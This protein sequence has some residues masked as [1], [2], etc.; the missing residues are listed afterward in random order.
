MLGARYTAAIRARRRNQQG[1]TAILFTMLSSLLLIPV[2]GLAIDGAVLYLM[3]AK[4]SAAVDATA[5]ATA[6]S[7]SVST[8]YAPAIATGKSYF[9]ANLPDGTFGAHVV[10]GEPLI[11][12][13]DTPPSTYTLTANVQASIQVPL[14]FMRVLGFQT[15]TL[16]DSGAASRRVS[17]IFLVLDR[18]GSLSRSGSCGPLRSSSQDFV[19]QFVDGRDTLALITFQSTA[20][21][22]YPTDGTPASTTFK[23]GSPTLTSVLSRL[24]CD[25]G[26]TTVAALKLAYEAIKQLNQ[27]LANNVIVL[28]TDGRANGF[29][30]EF[31]IKDKPDNR[32]DW[33]LGNPGNLVDM[34]AT[35]CTSPSLTGVVFS[36][37]GYYDPNGVLGYTAGVFE[38]KKEPLDWVSPSGLPEKLVDAS[39]NCSV[40]D[41]PQGHGWPWSSLA[42][43]T[44]I[45][46]L[47]VTGTDIWQN[48][49][50]GYWPLGNP[51]PPGSPYAGRPRID[52]WQSVTNASLN[53]ADHMADTIRSHGITIYTIGLGNLID[54]NFCERVANDPRAPGYNSN[55][56][57]GLFIYCTTAGLS[58]AFQQVASQILRLSK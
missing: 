54:V 52:T 19:N 7:L 24:K 47:P 2:A 27:P 46:S 42:L 41:T 14:Y 37:E 33:W 22:D 20:N 58:S 12:V 36:V 35:T 16:S 29:V 39:T 10:G 15:A 21:Q 31:P 48:P 17:N 23:T 9:A 44:D 34:P 13:P 5:L 40:A 1:A 43:R 49:L 8:S 25:G 55:Q 6:R 3:K 51:Y 18:S 32:Y 53:A 45:A 38:N 26:T 4:L 50:T 57:T 56:Q 28:F 30:G 11:S